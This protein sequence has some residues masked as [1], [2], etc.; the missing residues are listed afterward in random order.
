MKTTILVRSLLVMT[1]LIAP[2]SP[3][4]AGFADSLLLSGN[5]AN[6]TGQQ[7]RRG[8]RLLPPSVAIAVLQASSQLSQVPLLQLRIVQ[9]EPAVWPDNCLGLGTPEMFCTSALVKGWRVTVE[10]NQH[11]WVYRMNQSGSLVLIEEIR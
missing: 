7:S 5:S 11:Q 10:V 4:M 1:M 9:A 3:A 6:A 8:L 2:I